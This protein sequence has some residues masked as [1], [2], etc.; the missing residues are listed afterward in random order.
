MIFKVYIHSVYLLVPPQR[1]FAYTAP[2]PET[3][4]RWTGGVLSIQVYRRVS[5]CPPMMEAIVCLGS[6]LQ[7]L[8]IGYRAFQ[9]QG[10]CDTQPGVDLPGVSTLGIYMSTSSS[11]QVCAINHRGPAH[12]QPCAVEVA[13]GGR[14]T[15]NSSSGSNNI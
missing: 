12:T 8:T 5:E 2:F 14:N 10:D 13:W 1:S 3:S 9:G 11:V 7:A 6:W 15:T 4:V